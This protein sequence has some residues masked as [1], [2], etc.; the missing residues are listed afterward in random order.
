MTNYS[1]RVVAASAVPEAS[2]RLKELTA[3]QQEGRQAVA[4]PVQQSIDPGLGADP[5]EPLVEDTG[6][7]PLVVCVIGC[8]HPRKIEGGRRLVQPQQRR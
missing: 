3:T 7:D 5:P 1:R 6:S 4:Q 8:E 2:L